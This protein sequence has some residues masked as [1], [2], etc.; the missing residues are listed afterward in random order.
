MQQQAIPVTDEQR[1]A[2]HRRVM[3]RRHPRRKASDNLISQATTGQPKSDKEVGD[4]G[5]MHIQDERAVTP[6]RPLDI[7]DM[8]HAH[9]RGMGKSVCITTF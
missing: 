4:V 7:V 8:G 1:W 2:T 3:Q 5:V 6:H 9:P